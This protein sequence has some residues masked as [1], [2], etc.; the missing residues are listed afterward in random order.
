MR[1]S[2]TNLESRPPF[3]LADLYRRWAQTLRMRP[4]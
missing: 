2:L 3:D 1:F 4:L